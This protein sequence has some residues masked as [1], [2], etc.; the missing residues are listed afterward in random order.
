MITIHMIGWGMI[1][2]LP[3]HEVLLVCPSIHWANRFIDMSLILFLHCVGGISSTVCSSMCP[4]YYQHY[5]WIWL[6]SEWSWV[7]GWSKRFTVKHLD[8]VIAN[9]QQGC[10][11]AD[12]GP[13]AC[14]RKQSSQ[15]LTLNSEMGTSEFTI[16]EKLMNMSSINSFLRVNHID[17]KWKA[18]DI[19]SACQHGP[20]HLSEK[21]EMEEEV[22]KLTLFWFNLA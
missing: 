20:W 16:P 11:F 21:T 13:G 4:V 6:D 15:N 19:V 12:W 14:S 8:H 9:C 2:W 3:L 1:M 18:K 17:G 10:T 7:H 22:N 5:L